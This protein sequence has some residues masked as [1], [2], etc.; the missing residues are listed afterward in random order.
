MEDY[1][2]RGPQPLVRGPAPVHVIQILIQTK[3]DV[4]FWKLNDPSTL[5]PYYRSAVTADT[6]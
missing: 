4:L 2:D 5:A 1:I 3:K 6:G